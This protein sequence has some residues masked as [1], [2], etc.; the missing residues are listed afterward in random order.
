MVLF[1]QAE[2]TPW[3]VSSL[4]RMYFKCII[5][6]I[7]SFAII[8]T[9][10]ETSIFALKIIYVLRNPM[11]LFLSL[12]EFYCGFTLPDGK[13]YMTKD[14]FDDT[15]RTFIAGEGKMR[16]WLTMKWKSLQYFLP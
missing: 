16:I 8:N 15:L 14:N 3:V 7:W 1:R 6:N 10:L 12:F 4:E 13:P 2:L 5:D 9:S 11:D